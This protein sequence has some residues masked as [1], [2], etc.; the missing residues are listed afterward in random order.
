MRIFAAGKAGWRLIAVVGAVAVALAA[1]AQLA[2]NDG[3]ELW[4]FEIVN[5]YPHDP[6]AFTQGL[7]IHNGSLYEG[8]GQYGASTLR[9]VDLA[10]GRVE[11]SISLSNFHFGEGITILQDKIYQLTWQNNLTFIYDVATFERLGTLRN[12]GEGWGLTTNGSLLIVSDG[13][14]SIRFHHPET[15]A[16]IS[17]ITVLADGQPVNRL[18]ELEFV[19]GEIWANIWYQDRIARVSAD[20]GEVLGWIDLS[21]LNPARRGS[22]D[23]LNGIAYDPSS[24]RLFVT[25]KNWPT[26]Y[27]IEV[28]PQ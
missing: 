9:R 12:E 7:A 21:G 4:T 5:S 18:N 2:V 28:G 19:D 3:P 16:E 10:S 20:T 13:S 15:F 1:W 8:T 14:S 24:D 22:E 25:G 23:V 11:K 26:L 17:R 6:G 27:E